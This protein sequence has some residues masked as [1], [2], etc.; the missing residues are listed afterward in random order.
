MKNKKCESCMMPFSKDPGVRE[1]EQYCSYC[2]KNGKFTFEGDFGDF[3]KACYDAMRAK[4]MGKMKAGFFAWLTRFAPR[5][6]K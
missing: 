2:F 5:W 6:K 1:S 4:G 3:Q